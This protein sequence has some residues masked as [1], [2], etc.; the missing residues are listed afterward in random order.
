M[1]E[2]SPPVR[3][4]SAQRLFR[5]TSLTLTAGALVLPPQPPEPEETPLLGRRRDSDQ[6]QQ[7]LVSELLSFVG[8]CKVWLVLLLLLMFVTGV[9]VMVMFFQAIFATIFYQDKPCDQ[10]LLKWY[11]V[12]TLLWSQVPPC[13]SS[14]VRARLQML[15][16]SAL[17]SFCASVLF[18]LP[19]WVILGYGV[20][21]VQHA[22]TCP[23]TNPQLFYPI[24]RFIY[25]QIGVALIAFLLTVLGFFSLRYLLLALNR[26]GE[27][28]GCAKAV[29]IAYTGQ[30][31][32][33]FCT[34]FRRWRSWKLW[35]STPPTWQTLMARSWTAP[36]A[37]RRILKPGTWCGHPASTTSTRRACS[38]GARTTWTAPCAASQWG[39]L[40]RTSRKDQS[41]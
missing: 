7:R 40:T 3:G 5:A 20:Y 12:F 19:G 14:F 39:S 4:N 41:R 26:L 35:T 6:V 28:P 1:S 2:E 36:F 8:L 37:W 23:K 34:R 22:E 9:I 11:M 13:A 32:V 10:P 31:S 18:S 27:N 15:Q 17:V 38:P 25:A 30:P 16:Q 24:E 21:M 29:P 33:F